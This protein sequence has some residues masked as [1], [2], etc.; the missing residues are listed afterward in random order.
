MCSDHYS[1]G[2]TLSDAESQSTTSSYSDSKVQSVMKVSISKTNKGVK[3][4]KEFNSK[5]LN[6]TKPSRLGKS[7]SEFKS[8]DVSSILK[9]LKEFDQKYSLKPAKGQKVMLVQNDI[10]STFHENKSSSASSKK[11]NISLDLKPNAV[12]RRLLQS[13]Y[14]FGRS[15]NNNRSLL[16]SVDGTPV[17]SRKDVFNKESFDV[18]DTLEFNNKK[19]YQISNKSEFSLRN[20]VSKINNSSHIEVHSKSNNDFIEQNVQPA[21]PNAITRSENLSFQ[22]NERGAD[23]KVLS[24]NTSSKLEVQSKEMLEKSQDSVNSLC[25]GSHTPIPTECFEEESKAIKTQVSSIENSFANSE[26]VLNSKTVL[27][28]NTNFYLEKHTGQDLLS[29]DILTSDTQKITGLE[30][31]QDNS[32]MSEQSNL[33]VSSVGSYGLFK[34]GPYKIFNVE[35]LLTAHEVKVLEEKANSDI[36]SGIKDLTKNRTVSGKE[37]KINDNTREAIHSISEQNTALESNEEISE[38][39]EE[40][41]ESEVIDDL[42]ENSNMSINDLSVRTNSSYG[43]MM[44]KVSSHSEIKRTVKQVLSKKQNVSNEQVSISGRSLSKELMSNESKQESTDNRDV[45]SSSMKLES[46]DRTVSSAHGETSSRSPSDFEKSVTYR[47]NSNKTDMK[48]LSDIKYC[49]TGI[50]TDSNVVHHCVCGLRESSFSHPIF[51]ANTGRSHNIQ[52]TT[53]VYGY[54]SRAME[55]QGKTFPV[56]LTLIK[57]L[58]QQIELTRHFMNSQ[59]RMYEAYCAAV[60]N[61]S[62]DYKPVTLEDTRQYIRSHLKYRGTPREELNK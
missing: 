58:K 48:P 57:V 23:C 56:D 6:S 43:E 19:S 10:L 62:A 5:I 26:A 37:D 30:S 25:V 13:P 36:Q 34:S 51:P 46:E 52:E 61:I 2:Q 22:S 11:T 4:Q 35:D 42:P 27:L 29:G 7:N 31:N 28:H 41:I 1:F 59:Q 38:R 15:S 3:L 21:M 44:N 17:F 49:S 47:S 24:N 9:T 60:E 55:F 8:C 32:V 12:E 18:S 39:I 54:Y 33:S 20:P 16:S 45:L 53:P 40:E 14:L 50:Q